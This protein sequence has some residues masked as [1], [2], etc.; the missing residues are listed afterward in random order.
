MTP[1]TREVVFQLSGGGLALAI[2]F[3][4][5]WLGQV[6]F[7]RFGVLALFVCVPAGVI[8]GVLLIKL[9]Q[10]AHRILVEEG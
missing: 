4:G 2:A 3:G 10:F 7:G 9:L 6:L 5:T 8:T 1:K